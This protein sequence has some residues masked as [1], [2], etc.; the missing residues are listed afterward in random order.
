MEILKLK[1]FSNVS[2]KINSKPR[3]QY[4]CTFFW[5][6]TDDVIQKSRI[7]HS[8]TL[9]GNKIEIYFI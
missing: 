9:A 3:W 8:S 1:S 2:C 5:S 7:Q 4:I 6:I